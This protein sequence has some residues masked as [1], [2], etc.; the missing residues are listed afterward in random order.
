MPGRLTSSG[1]VNFGFRKSGAAKGGSVSLI[2]RAG[3]VL[4]GLLMSAPTPAAPL[5]DFDKL[6]DDAHPAATEQK[7]AAL[8]PQAT[9]A[10]NKDYLAQLLTQLARTQSLQL[11]LEEAHKTLDEAKNLLTADLKRASVRYLLERGRAFNGLPSAF[12]A[13]NEPKYAQARECFLAAWETAKVA[14]EDF[15]AADAA[16][17]MALVTPPLEALSW[18]ETAI[19]FIEQSKDDRT[20][21]WLGP[22]LNN[23][24]W[25]YHD[26]GKYAEALP[27]FEKDTV[28]RTSL[29]KLPQARI[30]RWSAAVM[31]R[32]LGQTQDALV[33]QLVLEKEWAEAGKPDGY[34]FEEIAESHLA[35]GN[36]A[37]AKKYF[38]LAYAQLSPD[39]TLQQT[40][41]KRLERL[42]TLGEA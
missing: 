14:G 31:L 7:F 12:D 3:L 18:N 4:L 19:T 17:M 34:V 13:T 30:A 29:N 35:L 33:R 6:W 8:V 26:L 2:L 38:A 40:E 20:K 21:K 22:L 28:Y 37:E 23:T 9:A 5:P 39:D 1:P 15:Y 10:N 41:P 16:H 25:A 24:G 27:Y 11:K 32:K 42:K 36:P